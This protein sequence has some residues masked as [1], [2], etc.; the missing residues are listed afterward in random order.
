M[1]ANWLIQHFNAHADQIAKL[2]RMIC[3][4]R[5]AWYLRSTVSLCGTVSLAR[6]GK[7]L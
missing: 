7:L 5:V 1:W 2:S 6:K 3:S 4:V